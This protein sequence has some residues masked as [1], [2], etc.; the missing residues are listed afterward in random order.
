MISACDAAST[1]YCTNRSHLGGEYLFGQFGEFR[2]GDGYIPLRQL[3]TS[4][5]RI[6]GALRLMVLPRKTR[7]QCQACI[8]GA[9]YGNVTNGY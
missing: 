3:S 8:A 5:K 9:D 2:F 4:L 1:L 6:F 7:S